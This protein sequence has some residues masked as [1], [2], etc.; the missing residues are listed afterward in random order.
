MLAWEF[1]DPAK[2]SVHHLTVPTF[3]IQHP[4]ELSAHGWQEMA[5]VLRA[6][7]Q[8]VSPQVMRVHIR[9]QQ[10]HRESLRRGLPALPRLPQWSVSVHTCCVD[11]A[12][13]YCQRVREWAA[14]TWADVEKAGL[15]PL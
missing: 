15:L 4:A 10:A 5:A 7:V 1:S 14:A 2:G 13:L 9:Q 11:D 3:H 12:V 8:G 6:F